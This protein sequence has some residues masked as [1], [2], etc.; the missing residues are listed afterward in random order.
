MQPGTTQSI[1]HLRTVISLELSE[2]NSKLKAI[3]EI[4]PSNSAISIMT[5]TTNAGTGGGYFSRE[6]A[7]ME[8]KVLAKQVVVLKDKHII[9]G[10]RER[11]IHYLAATCTL[12][13]TFGAAR[14]FVPTIWEGELDTYHNI[15]KM[16]VG[17]INKLKGVREICV[18]YDM[19]DPLEISS[20]VYETATDPVV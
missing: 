6:T 17:N 10:S 13:Q 14:H 7:R 18:K 12:E 16:Y 2:D 20:V 1:P 4:D 3:N 15:Q 9:P 11:S 19:K 5:D 8:A